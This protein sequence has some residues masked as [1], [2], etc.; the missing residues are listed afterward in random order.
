M[1][2]LLK[3]VSLV[4]MQRKQQSYRSMNVSNF[5]LHDLIQAQP[6]LTFS[7]P[8]FFHFAISIASA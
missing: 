6:E 7:Y 1:H 4:W 8:C 3:L 5:L 2:V